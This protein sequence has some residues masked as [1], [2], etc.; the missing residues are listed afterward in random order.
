MKHDR[1]LLEHILEAIAST[2]L[3]LK[4]SALSD[5]KTRSAV[6]RQIGIIGEAARKLSQET[7]DEYPHVPWA[8]IV[9]TR[10]IVIHDYLGVS[11]QIIA[12]IVETDLPALKIHIL[13]MLN[14]FSQP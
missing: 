12:A 13:A 10:N 11:P 14:D 5:A 8:K 9:A 7:K 1:P 2:E 4:D 3:F 6:E